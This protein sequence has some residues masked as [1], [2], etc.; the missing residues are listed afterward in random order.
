M[1]KRSKKIFRSKK[2]VEMTIPVI[3]AIV[4]GLTIM[5]VSLFIIMGRGKT[6]SKVG[7]CDDACAVSKDQCP[8]DK[9]TLGLTPCT[10][11]D[12]KSGHCCTDLLGGG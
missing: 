12:G 1:R 5:V 9:P 2:G 4:L 6:L 3:I 8:D 10:T 7:A 11:K